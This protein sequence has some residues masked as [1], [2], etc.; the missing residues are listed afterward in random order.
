MT[1]DLLYIT[2]PILSAIIP[3]AVFLAVMESSKTEGRT[4]SRLKGQRA[5]G[6]CGICTAAVL[7]AWSVGI[8]EFVIA[9][10]GIGLALFFFSIAVISGALLDV[11]R[12]DPSMLVGGKCRNCKQPPWRD[13]N[14]PTGALFTGA[15]GANPINGVFRHLRTSENPSKPRFGAK[16]SNSDW[17]NYFQP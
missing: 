5:F 13:V 11:A 10:M 8:G 17:T 9:L 15:G 1:A 16:C 4:V 3:L 14:I 12:M 7:F 6:I 2:A